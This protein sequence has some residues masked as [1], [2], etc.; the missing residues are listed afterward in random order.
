MNM[1]F[2]LVCACLHGFALMCEENQKLKTHMAIE[3][4]T[5]VNIMVRVSKDGNSLP[6]FWSH[7]R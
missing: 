6:V 7:L 2:L 3:A 1:C 4:K 5:C